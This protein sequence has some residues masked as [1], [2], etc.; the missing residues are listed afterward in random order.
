LTLKLGELAANTA[1]PG[2]KTGVIA[3]V[4]RPNVGKSTLVNALVGAKVSI[5]SSKPQTTRHRI[6]GVRTEADAQYIFADTPGF[7]TQFK[8]ALNSAMNRTVTQA[9]AEVDVVLWLVEARKFTAADQRIL[10]L[11]PRDK[12]VVLVVNKIDLVEDKTKLLP[13][14]ESMA[15]QFNF[16][17]IVP[18][19]A[20]KEKDAIRLPAILKPY[21]PEGEAWFSEDD[22]TDRSSRF[23]AAEIVREKVFRLT[24]DEIP[25]VVAVTIEQFEEDGAMF[26][27]GAVIWVDRD[28]HKPIVLGRGGEHIKRIA[29]EARV[30]MEK[31][32]DRKVFLQVWVKVKGGWADDSRLIKQFGYE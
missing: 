31:L 8:S 2:F 23:L 21:L 13:F 10:P 6:L 15:K 32:F 29:S 26:R 11:L 20:E 5:V 18:L 1:I 17:E 3:V 22:I 30:D 27:I 19:S 7:Q 9:L 25:Y 16:A 12:P 14:L 28:G 24:G 4:G